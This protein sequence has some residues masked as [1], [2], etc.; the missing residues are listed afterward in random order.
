M[1]IDFVPDGNV[2]SEFSPVLTGQTA[3]DNQSDE[4]DIAT[5]TT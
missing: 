5:N 3:D 1:L 2:I 4:E